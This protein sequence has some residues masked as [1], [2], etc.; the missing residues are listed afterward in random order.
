MSS[1][2][3]RPRV[4]D[5]ESEADDLEVIGVAIMQGTTV[6]VLE[7]EDDPRGETMPL[8]AFRSRHGKE[9]DEALKCFKE[10]IKAAA[11]TMN[12][13]VWTFPAAQT[14]E[15]AVMCPDTEWLMAATAPVKASSIAEA[16]TAG[17]ITYRKCSAATIKDLLKRVL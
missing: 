11:N 6:V 5:D 1:P 17:E 13:I 7:S 9:A 3:K 14:I 16:V 4:S 15:A 8:T 10:Y 12:E 2:L